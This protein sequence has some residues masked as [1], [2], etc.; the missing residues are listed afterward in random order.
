MACCA[1]VSPS[2]PV[3]AATLVAVVLLAGVPPAAAASSSDDAVRLEVQAEPA[4]PFVGERVLYRVRITAAIPLRRLTLS[5]PEA[6]DV[7]VIRLG[8]DRQWTEARDGG[9]VRMLERW[10]AI[11]P[12]RTGPVRIAGPRLLA[13][14][15]RSAGGDRGQ[16]AAL[17]ERFESLHRQARDLTLRVQPPP[18]RAEAPWLPA[19]SVSISEEWAPPTTDLRVGT[20][21]TRSIR[22]DASG[23]SAAQLPDL[24]LDATEGLKVYAGQP[25]VRERV[26]GGD[27]LASK[28]IEIRYVPTVPGQQR[29]PALRLPWWS[30]GADAPRQVRLPAREIKVT[31]AAGTAEALRGT[32]AQERQVFL[33]A[34]ADD[35]WQGAWLSGFFAL[36]WLA[37]AVL[38]WL[39]RKRRMRD[40]GGSAAAGRPAPKSGL[41]A[42]LSRL[43]RACRAGDAA[44][45]RAAL[46]EWGRTRWPVQPPRGPDQ[47]LLRLGADAAA[48]EQVCRL[49]RHLYADDARDDRPAWEPQSMLN[50][51]KPWLVAAHDAADNAAQS[52]PPLYPSGR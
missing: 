10:Y 17:I 45:A 20:P 50:A 23:V 11:V 37:T 19:E 40:R 46:L 41:D 43:E 15:A 44:D 25:Q 27:L 9:R 48:R 12:Q 18:P 16:E 13:A 42:P 30:L 5:E 8:E 34:A 52:L 24:P 2:C 14:A 49:E 51:I 28:S 36:G 31:G 39:E 22:I 32:A 47:L 4:A 1:P 7:R 6:E 21:V 35:R 3:R 33:D 38:W 26:S 29:I